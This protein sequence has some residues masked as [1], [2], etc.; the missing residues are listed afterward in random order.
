MSSDRR[1]RRSVASPPA[2][3][4]TPSTSR[5]LETTLPVIDPRTTSGSPSL[6]ANSA[7]ISSGA[8]P[9]LALRKPP[10]P[11][12]VCS[13]A[14]SVASP[15]SHA[16]GTSDSAASANSGTSPAWKT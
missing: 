6:T 15:I 16:S 13:P 5:M 12:P 9:K 14:C 1:S 8:F 11:G 10:I 2:T 4:A 3:I 7:M